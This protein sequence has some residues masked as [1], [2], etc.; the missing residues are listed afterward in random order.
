MTKKNDTL[1]YVV[2]ADVHI[3]KKDDKKLKEELDSHF[4]D[5]IR[6]THKESGLDLIVIAGDLFDRVLRFNEYSGLLA[7]DFMTN[8]EEF[9]F[10]NNIYLRILKGTKSHD[11]SQLD[12]FTNLEEQFSNFKIIRKVATESLI[13]KDKEFKILYLPEEYPSDPT[14]YY[15]EYFDV[16]KNTYDLTFGHGMIDFVA[17]TGYE[18]D[19]ENEAKGTPTHEAKTLMKITAGPVIFGHIHDFKE[20]K[21]QVYYPGSFTRYS[22]DTQEDKGFLYVEVDMTNS[23][24]YEVSFY[25]NDSAPTYGVIFI[26]ELD[27]KDSNDLIRLVNKMRKDFDFVKIKTNDKNNLNIVRQI[28]ESDTSIKIQALDVNREIP[29]MDTKYEFIIK[30]ELP[31]AST[32]AKFIEIKEEKTIPINR[33]N[34]IINAEDVPLEDIAKATDDKENKVTKVKPVEVL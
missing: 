30:G 17:F 2:L 10:D 15:E 27:Y 22:F 12:V 14:S 11:Y 19:S 28:T 20:Y 1:N 9:C 29:K 21:D 25:E 3:G 31:I 4:F 24:K 34:M 32:I 13:I 7:I 8:L 6:S 16:K 5:F 33:V 23:A 18:D 26:D